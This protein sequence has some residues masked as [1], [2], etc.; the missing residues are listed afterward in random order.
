MI[1]FGAGQAVDLIERK[2]AVLQNTLQNAE[3]LCEIPQ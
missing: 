2:A 3:L 1:F